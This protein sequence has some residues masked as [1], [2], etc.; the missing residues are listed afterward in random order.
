MRFQPILMEISFMK[1]N[2]KKSVKYLLN[3]VSNVH[4]QGEKKNIF[5][6]STPR[7][8][9]TWLMEII[10]SQSGFKFY[11]E[12]FNIRR[13]NVQKAGYFSDWDELLRE[14][15]IMK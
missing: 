3:I 10:A 1:M 8:G 14:K 13:E 12:P 11:D 7:S 5:I 4:I 9:S 6:F 2:F 15:I